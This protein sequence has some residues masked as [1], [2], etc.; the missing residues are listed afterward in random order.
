MDNQGFRILIVEDHDHTA[1]RLKRDVARHPKLS[2]CAVASGLQSGLTFLYQHKPRVVLCDL[3]LPDGDGIDLIKAVKTCDWECDS[4]VISVFGDE[5]R[6]LTAISAGA[7]GYILKNSSEHD[8]CAD[9]LSVIVGGSPISPKIARRLLTLVGENASFKPAPKG[10]I[11]LTPR[12]TEILQAV[13]RGFK[14]HEIGEELSISAGTVGNHINNIYKKLEVSSSI[15]A[16]T[17]ANKMG[18]L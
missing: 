3:G 13:A 5:E 1:T 4:L 7:N 2:V 17:R 9:I 12:E 16:L 14:R 11:L 15:D 6:V 8:I 18:L 10:K